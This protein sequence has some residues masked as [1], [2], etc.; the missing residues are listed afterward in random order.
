MPQRRRKRRYRLSLRGKAALQKSIQETKPWK[1][2]TGP[3]TAVGKQAVG[4][5]N[6]KHGYYSKTP[7]DDAAA[8]KA[9]MRSYHR[10][11]KGGG[12]K[13]KDAGPPVW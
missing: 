4:Q 9:F 11:T 3:R 7:F 12:G 6:F 10:M 8:F 5:N 2:S 1:W 13:R